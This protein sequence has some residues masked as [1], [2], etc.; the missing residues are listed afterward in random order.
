MRDPEGRSMNVTS[1]KTPHTGS[2]E[3]ESASASSRLVSELASRIGS[4]GVE[5]AGVAGN[6]DEAS[7]RRCN[8]AD[9]FK[10]LQRAAEHMVAGN[11][12]IDRAAKGA[13]QAAS[14]A[15]NEIAESR[16]LIGGGVQ[17]IGDLTGAVTQIPQSLASFSTLL[18]HVGRVAESIDTI[19]R[20]TRLLSLNAS[21]EAAR[22]G[23]AG[24]GFAV[25]AGGGEGP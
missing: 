8:E 1:G 18:K 25:V 14:A 2:P 13:Q 20:Q 11:R 24:R 9:Q 4:L 3:P 16:L 6:L 23:E 21:I 17:H 5:L 15:G 10:E 19:A 7:G 22:A 12:E